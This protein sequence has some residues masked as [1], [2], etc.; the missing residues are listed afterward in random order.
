HYLRAVRYCSPHAV[1]VK[2]IRQKKSRT[3]HRVLK[4]PQNRSNR[5]RRKTLKSQKRSMKRTKSTNRAVTKRETSTMEKRK[6][7]TKNE[8]SRRNIKRQPHAVVFS[9]HLAP[10]F[11]EKRPLNDSKKGG[12]WMNWKEPLRERL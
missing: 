7:M 3:I 1:T 12:G 10:F 4:N 2:S 11:H 5:Q 6:R 9:L 8:K